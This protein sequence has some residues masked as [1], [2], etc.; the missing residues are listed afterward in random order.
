MRKMY[1]I[2]VIILMKTI[3][4]ADDSSDETKYIDLLPEKEKEDF[5]ERIARRVFDGVQSK[6]DRDEVSGAESDAELDEQDEFVKD[7]LKEESLNLRKNGDVDNDAKTADVIDPGHKEDGENPFKDEGLNKEDIQDDVGDSSL[8]DLTLRDGKRNKRN[9]FRKTNEDS[10]IIHVSVDNGEMETPEEKNLP[11]IPLAQDQ[12]DQDVEDIQIKNSKWNLGENTNELEISTQSS[13]ITQMVDFNDDPIKED[14]EELVTNDSEKTGTAPEI[15]IS[16]SPKEYQSHETKEK[17]SNVEEN[18]GYDNSDNSKFGSTQKIFESFEKIVD[19]NKDSEKTASA[20]QAIQ[21]TATSELTSPEIKTPVE[22]TE[23]ISF[24][25]NSSE[26]HKNV[27]TNARVLR[28]Y[29]KG[30]DLEDLKEPDVKDI[31]KE[32]SEDDAKENKGTLATVVTVHVLETQTN[33]NQATISGNDLQKV[34]PDMITTEGTSVTYKEQTTEKNINLDT[35]TLNTEVLTKHSL[36]TGEEAKFEED[37]KEINRGKIINLKQKKT[38]HNT[39]KI[40]SKELGG[41]LLKKVLEKDD[42]DIPL[43][44]NNKTNEEAKAKEKL[45]KNTYNFAND[46]IKALRTEIIPAFNSD[47]KNFNGLRALYEA[48]KPNEYKVYAVRKFLNS[49]FILFVKYIQ[50]RAFFTISD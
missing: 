15:N 30:E 29:S 47:E 31:S 49:F 42:K 25:N 2:L 50:I 11:N 46:M 7:I 44:V 5:L 21:S 18:T 35:T 22:I 32:N 26:S 36:R 28:T 3:V 27:S 4:S 16:E 8:V 6:D 41:E 1:V 38:V 33:L 13:Q 12:D 39:E 14:S 45:D 48:T 37:S 34:T 10:K 23:K 43:E 9:S 19:V 40:S 24:E 20:P 17:Q